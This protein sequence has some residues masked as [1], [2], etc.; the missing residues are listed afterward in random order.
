M[1][2]M[3]KDI[4]KADEYSKNHREKDRENLS[5]FMP[6]IPG[7]DTC[8][9]ASFLKYMS[10]LNPSCNRLWQRPRDT[11][12]DSDAKWHVNC[13]VGAKTISKFITNLSLL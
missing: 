4:A 1:H 13:P 11:F 8:P 6:E 9:V 12:D 7:C 5:R 2:A 10:K 3:T